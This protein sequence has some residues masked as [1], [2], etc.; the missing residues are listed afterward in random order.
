MEQNRSRETEVSID[1]KTGREA[2]KIILAQ[3]DI[4]L[5]AEGKHAP[6][7]VQV[8]KP[9]QMDKVKEAIH[10]ARDVHADLLVFPEMSISEKWLDCIK[11][12]FLKSEYPKIL[13]LPLEHMTLCDWKNLVKVDRFPDAKTPGK[14]LQLLKHSSEQLEKEYYINSAMIWYREHSQEENDNVKFVLKTIHQPKLFP[15]KQEQHQAHPGSVF[16]G[17]S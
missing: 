10:V 8:D 3:I 13:I 9:N 7:R 6:Y 15:N 5:K 16:L 11:E 4:H 1:I 14:E 17:S 12:A 2:T